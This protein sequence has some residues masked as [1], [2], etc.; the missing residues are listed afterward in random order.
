MA[1]TK[2]ARE[3]LSVFDGIV[4]MEKSGEYSNTKLRKTSGMRLNNFLFGINTLDET[5][6]YI[7]I[8]EWATTTG[9]TMTI[10]ARSLTRPGFLIAWTTG[11]M[12]PTVTF[13]Q[14]S[15]HH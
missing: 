12:V 3:L 9:K 6:S 11:G 10:K 2:K 14:K 4:F 5:M 1:L 8:P 15:T 13:T 7:S